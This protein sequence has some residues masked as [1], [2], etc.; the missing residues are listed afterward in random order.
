[1]RLTILAAAATLFLSGCYQAIVTN[2]GLRPGAFDTLL[3]RTESA[4]GIRADRSVNVRVINAR[5]LEPIAMEAMHDDWSTDELRRYEDSLITMGLWPPGRDLVQQLA[6]TIG[7]EAV[8]LYVPDERTL[9]VVRDPD[10]PFAIR[11]VSSIARRDIAREYALAHELVHFLQHQEY[12]R[13]FDAVLGMK[14]SDDAAWA[15][16]AAIEGDAVRYGFAALG[17][18]VRAPSAVDFAQELEKATSHRAFATQPR[19]L[20]E[21]LVFPYISGYRLSTL[22]ATLLLERPPASTEQAMHVERRREPF[23]IIDIPTPNIAGCEPVWTNSLG[24]LGISILLRDFSPASPPKSWVGW[25]GDRYLTMNCG[26]SRSLIWLTTWDSEGDARE[27][28]AAYEAIAPAIALRAELAE[29]P[30]VEVRGRDA[31]VYAPALETMAENIARTAKRRTARTFNDVT[32]DE[33]IRPGPK[34]PDGGR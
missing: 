33:P 27:F 5:E 12:P 7:T 30:T 11:F 16:Q 26:D 28:A 3:G 21:T 24:E 32:E 31:L 20:R 10:I 14:H 23:T 19:L 1:V 25:D 6:S 2:E 4:R 8:G 29:V 22:E 18:S 9:Y 15:G 34:R 13:V 17:S